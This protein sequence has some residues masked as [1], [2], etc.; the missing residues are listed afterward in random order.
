[1]WDRTNK[2]KK[3]SVRLPLFLIEMIEEIMPLYDNNF[4][5]ALIVILE[6]WRYSNSH[7]GLIEKIATMRYEMLL[8]KAQ[9]EEK[10]KKNQ[11]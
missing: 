2:T 11:S 7:K 3:V 9:L 5:K 4:S 1:M 8:R 10:M 6:S